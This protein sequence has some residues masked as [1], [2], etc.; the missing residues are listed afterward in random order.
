MRHRIPFLLFYLAALVVGSAGI[1]QATP[2]TTVNGST[3]LNVTS[4]GAL[5]GLGVTVAPA[6]TA[7][8]VTV[9]SLPSPIVFYPVTSVDLDSGEIFHVGAVLD[10]TTTATVSL[11][12]F[13]VDAGAGLVFANVD[14]PSDAD[15]MSAAIFSINKSCSVAD[16]CL[17]LDGTSTISGLELTLTSAAAGIL[18]A[19]LGIADLTGASVAVANSSFT[20]V[21][22]P[23]TGLLT[24]TG[25]MIL[26][27]TRRRDPA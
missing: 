22:E 25:L 1:G 4:F 18:V 12:D 5:T 10:L 17:G 23:S 21:P 19:D 2:I 6:G 14:R 7:Q 9:P 11:S 3:Q 24:L 26:G 8:V 27:L 20:L 16:P 13:V 15:L